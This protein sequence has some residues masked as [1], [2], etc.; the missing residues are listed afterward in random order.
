[1]AIR[2]EIT[3]A[4]KQTFITGLR[5]GWTVA[6]T[7]GYLGLPPHSRALAAIS[8]EFF[9]ARAV[10]EAARDVIP[11]I[12]SKVLES[13]SRTVSTDKMD[14]V[15][16]TATRITTLPQLIAFC[17][18]DETEWECRDATFNKWEIGA[19][20]DGAIT[21]APLFQVKARFIPRK[22]AIQAKQIISDL[23]S[24]LQLQIP[25]P[26]TPRRAY[27][28]AGKT[29]QLIHIPDLHIGKPPAEG[30][31]ID[32]GIDESVGVFLGKMEELL[33]R[34]ALLHGEH[35]GIIFPIGGDLIHVDN[36]RNETSSGTRIE[37]SD[38]YRRI[39]KAARIA[40]FEAIN[41]A[42]EFAPV[43]T[44]I[45]PGNHGNQSELALGDIVEVRY[46]G[47]EYVTVDNGDNPRKYFPYGLNL[48]GFTHS[49]KE[50]NDMLPQIMAQ[51]VPF[52]WGETLFREWHTQHKH[53]HGKKV[54]SPVA[55]VA[56]VILR[57]TSSIC[58]TDNWHR[59]RGYIGNRRQAESYVYG[60]DVGPLAQLLAVV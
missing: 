19:V 58:V 26:V 23:L 46:S 9:A 48:F 1:M 7:A 42:L 35:D 50:K 3:D 54:Y 18:I 10:E 16:R 11:D 31:D 21:E 41:L 20:I 14:V 36:A 39:F 55:E 38:S 40:I 22:G 43:H 24:D 32:W 59:E 15:I 28:S 47:S 45:V 25:R 5:Q 8:K 34:G 51:E 33:E 52:L 17:E 60:H 4:Q 12:P 53:T 44:L 57:S 49:D 27:S 56:G 13:D 6:E 30:D 29:A 37:A 2:H